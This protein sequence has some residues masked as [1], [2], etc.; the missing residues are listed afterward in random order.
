MY[1]FLLRMGTIFTEMPGWHYAAS[2]HKKEVRLVGLRIA[3]A[4]R[5][6][7]GATWTFR[8]RALI[9]N[10]LSPPILCVR[11]DPELFMA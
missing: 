1:G 10:E 8:L 3:A 7:E 4:I 9:S 2:T 11:D 6:R 5:V